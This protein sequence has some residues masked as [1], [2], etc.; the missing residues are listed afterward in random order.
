M[1]QS[2]PKCQKCNSD[3]SHTGHAEPDTDAGRKA[4]EPCP[5]CGSPVSCR[6]IGDLGAADHYFT[7]EHACERDGCKYVERFDEF[8]CDGYDDRKTERTGGID[9]GCPGCSGFK[10]PVFVRR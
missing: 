1:G 3:A 7:W 4:R 5:F 9:G 8:S 10:K 2:G 6:Y